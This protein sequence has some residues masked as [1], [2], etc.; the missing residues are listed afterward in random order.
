MKKLLYLLLMI[1]MLALV[2]CSDDDNDVPDV[3]LGFTYSG[4]T[5]V[6]GTLYT[7]QGDTLGID[8]V[9]CT[10]TEGTKPAMIANVT[11][12]LDGRPLG[13]SPVAP[14]SI[15]LLTDEMPVGRHT[16]TLEM[17]VLQEGKSI[18]TGWMPIPVAVVDTVTDIPAGANPP[19]PGTP[20]TYTGTATINK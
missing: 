17:T 13:Y 5:D 16:L 18:G 7:V 12:V 2:A 10:P 19:A 1:P 11:Y 9:Y 4:A 6:D 20:S 15:S 8:S 3:K 14:F